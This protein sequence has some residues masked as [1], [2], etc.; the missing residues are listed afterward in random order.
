MRDMLAIALA[1]QMGHVLTPELAKTIAREA[2]S[3]LDLTVDP[4]QFPPRHRDGILFQCERLLDG[5]LDLR[6]HRTKYLDETAPGAPVR[7]D[8][9]RLIDLSRSGRQVIFTARDAEDQRLIGSVWLWLSTSIDTGRRCVTD[10]LLYVNPDFRNRLVGLQLIQYAEHCVFALGVREASFHFRQA[11]GAD[12][13]AR[14][15]GYQPD[16]QRVTKTHHGDQFANV[17]TRHTKEVFDGSV[18]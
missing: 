6:E 18:A 15:L 7:I 2:I 11:N 14:Y 3:E 17:P 8:W 16:S 4:W 9:A 13:M 1:R 5:G 12:R 10:D